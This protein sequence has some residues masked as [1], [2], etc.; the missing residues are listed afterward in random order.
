MSTKKVKKIFDGV[1]TEFN[2]SNIR[3][4]TH[5]KNGNNMLVFPWGYRRRGTFRGKNS[6]SF[7][8]SFPP[9]LF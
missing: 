4:Y 3:K 7:F 9:I 6:F 5:K 1:I 8:F 2:I